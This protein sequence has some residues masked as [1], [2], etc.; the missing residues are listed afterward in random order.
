MSMISSL[1]RIYILSLTSPF[2]LEFWYNLQFSGKDPS[3]EKSSRSNPWP[4]PQINRTGKPARHSPVTWQRPNMISII[5]SITS[6]IGWYAWWTPHYLADCV[7]HGFAWSLAHHRLSTH[8]RCTQL[9]SNSAWPKPSQLS[10]L[11][12]PRPF[13]LL[14]FMSS[15]IQSLLPSYPKWKT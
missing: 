1:Q 5:C 10:S 7:S 8:L 11:L 12:S 15:L 6:T 2:C 14:W 4:F 13:S 3:S 9:N